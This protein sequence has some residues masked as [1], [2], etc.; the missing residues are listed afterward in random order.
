MGSASKVESKGCGG[1]WR[2]GLVD[3]TILWG[4]L[5]PTSPIL[6]VFCGFSGRGHYLRAAYCQES[7]S[8]KGLI[9]SGVFFAV[10]NGY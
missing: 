6:L 8:L 10:A 4:S 5:L 1:L 2:E 9:A 3:A 7:I